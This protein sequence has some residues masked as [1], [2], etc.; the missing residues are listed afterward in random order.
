M[1]KKVLI[2]ILIVLI[3]AGL[4]YVAFLKSNEVPKTNN[5]AAVVLTEAEKQTLLQ[6]LNAKMA[7]Y[8]KIIEDLKKKITEIQNA[9]IA[10]TTHPTVSITSP[11]NGSTVSGT[12]NINISA[13]DNVGVTSCNFFWDS[14]DKGAMTLV[15]GNAQNGVWAKTYTENVAGTHVAKAECRDAANNL[16]IG[17]DTN[18]EVTPR[19]CTGNV[20]LLLSPNPVQRGGR[21][22]ATVYGLSSECAG[23]D[24]LIRYKSSNGPLVTKCTLT[25]S[26]MCRAFFI[27]PGQPGFHP[28]FALVDKNN[29][30]RYDWSFGEIGYA[31]LKVLGWGWPYP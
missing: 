29:D 25:S 27:A 17:P 30:G 2:P 15:S 14:V 16:G 24:A 28:Y 23:K 11:A 31:L 10:D 7:E 4:I 8:L 1:S 13:T 6:E 9:P 21:V 12:I 5:Q 19:Q 22:T 18:I 20:R 3:V 26:G